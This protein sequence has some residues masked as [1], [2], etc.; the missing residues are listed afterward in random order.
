MGFSFSMDNSEINGSKNYIGS[1]TASTIHKRNQRD[2]SLFK[3][4]DGGSGRTF[5]AKS[6]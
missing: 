2:H 4:M 3:I 1:K 5:S 6:D